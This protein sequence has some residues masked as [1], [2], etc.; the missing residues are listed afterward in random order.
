MKVKMNNG[1]F[2]NKSYAVRAG[3]RREYYVQEFGELSIDYNEMNQPNPTF[4]SRRGTY[5]K[6]NVTLKDGTK[7]FEWM[8]WRT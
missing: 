3:H 4:K 6:S 2:H 7:V 1:P 5:A 8:G